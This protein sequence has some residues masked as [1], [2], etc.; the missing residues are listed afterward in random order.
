MEKTGAFL[1]YK[2]ISKHE[3]VIGTTVTDSF[4]IMDIPITYVLY[5]LKYFPFSFLFLRFIN[6]WSICTMYLIPK[7]TFPTYLTEILSDIYKNINS[8]LFEKMGFYLS[9]DT[10]VEEKFSD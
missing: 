2:P 8:S 1:A 6:F 3:E 5:I 7:I 9:I 4:K 10:K